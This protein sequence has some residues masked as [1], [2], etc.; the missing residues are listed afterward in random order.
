MGKSLEESRRMMKA[1]RPDG[2]A[3]AAPAYLRDVLDGVSQAHN[4]LTRCLAEAEANPAH[5]LAAPGVTSLTNTAVAFAVAKAHE[6]TL[7]RGDV[8]AVIVDNAAIKERCHRVG[9]NGIASLTHTRQERNL[10]V[11]CGWRNPRQA[12]GKIEICEPE[13]W[14]YHNGGGPFIVIRASSPFPRG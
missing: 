11:P 13:R 14:R 3:K 4:S 6:V 8:T 5:P 9:Y 7:Q 2:S 10:F 12:S 1:L